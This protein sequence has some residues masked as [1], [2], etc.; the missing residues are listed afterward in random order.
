MSADCNDKIRQSETFPGQRIELMNW[1][2]IIDLPHREKANGFV[3][4]VLVPA[5]FK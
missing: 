4:T 1:Q 3:V 2:Y 5:E